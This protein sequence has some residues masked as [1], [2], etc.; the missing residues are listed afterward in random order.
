MGCAFSLPFMYASIDDKWYI[1]CA[2]GDQEGVL[3]GLLEALQSGSA[4]AKY[5]IPLVQVY[6]RLS[7]SF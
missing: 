7:K 6:I 1:F 5:A 2:A 3:D 4:F